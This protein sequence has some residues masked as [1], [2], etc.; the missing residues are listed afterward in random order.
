MSHLPEA[1]EIDD[2]IFLEL[3]PVLCCNFEGTHNIGHALCVYMEDWSVDG[4]CDICA[5]V[6][7]SLPIRSC[8]ESNLIIYYNVNSA[9]NLIVLQRL[10]L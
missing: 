4:F 8:S 3:L 9:S 7:R 2:Y 5:V 6:A 10:H 1:N